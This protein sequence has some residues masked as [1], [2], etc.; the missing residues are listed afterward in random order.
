MLDVALMQCMTAVN[1]CVNSTLRTLRLLLQIKPPRASTA[2][3]KG[4]A[5]YF[6][7][8]VVGRGLPRAAREMTTF[9]AISTLPFVCALLNNVVD[10]EQLFSCVIPLAII[11]F[12]QQALD[13]HLAWMRRLLLVG[14]P[15]LPFPKRGVR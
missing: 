15:F 7:K 5:Q 13:L 9:Y 12:L 3:N 8:S 4:G 2:P 1:N 6:V 10:K 14:A 11:D